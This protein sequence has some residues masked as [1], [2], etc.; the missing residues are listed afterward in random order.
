MFQELLVAMLRGLPGL[1]RTTTASSAAE[2]IDLSAR[3]RPD[4]L[5]LDIVLPDA[6]G[7]SVAKALQVLNPEAR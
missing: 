1:S 6:E 4:L 3:I 7:L 5:I 2:G